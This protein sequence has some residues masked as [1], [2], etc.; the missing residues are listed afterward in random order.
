[1]ANTTLMNFNKSIKTSIQLCKLST[2][3]FYTILEIQHDWLKIGQ[4][5][6]ESNNIQEESLQ[7]G[8]STGEFV[9]ILVRDFQGLLVLREG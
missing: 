4:V 8:I 7:P 3:N 9:H 5:T 2:Y 1:M 6:Y